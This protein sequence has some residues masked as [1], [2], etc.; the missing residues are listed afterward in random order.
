MT[1]QKIANYVSKIS[2][3]LLLGL[4]LVWF[5]AIIASSP[6]L[7]STSA[8]NIN[9]EAAE[10]PDLTIELMPDFELSSSQLST[11][12]ETGS[13]ILTIPWIAQ[14]IQGLYKYG[15]A[16]AGVVAA[17]M[18]MVGGFLYLTAADSGRVSRG[19]QIIVDAMLGLLL[20]IFA[21][22]ILTVINP[23]LTTLSP[24]KVEYIERQTW[25]T[26]AT[27]TI[28][29]GNPDAPVPADQASRTSSPVPGAS[30]PPPAATSCSPPCGPSR[31]ASGPVPGSFSASITSCPYTPQVTDSQAGKKAISDKAYRE[32]FYS[33]M[34]DR[35]LI[36]ASTI[37]ER[38]VLIAQAAAACKVKIG[39]CG[40]T[41]G[42]ISALAGVGRANPPTCMYSNPNSCN[43]TRGQA[44]N[45]LTSEQR[46]QVY[47]RRCDWTPAA[48]KPAGTSA[49]ATKAREKNVRM[50]AQYDRSDCV[51][52]GAAAKAGFIAFMQAEAAAGRV[53]DNWPDGWADKLRPGDYF[54]C[55][56]G[57]ADLTGSH[58]LVFLGWQGNRAQVVD[59]S[60]GGAPS[61]HTGPCL[62]SSCGASLCPL[63]GVYSAPN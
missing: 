36:R 7:A 58:A 53:R 3:L 4:L 31:P 15:V 55:Y 63:T 30:A 29:T 39:S 19:K 10:A 41:A 8:A 60:Y 50:H 22:G 11:D 57:N 49:S 47:A 5:A 59:A 34:L 48:D 25:D 33:K 62:K 9:V 18:M 27:T 43:G 2:A 23:G 54:V 42:T 24:L 1:A 44:L 35:S 14:Y 21:Y 61:F 51:S 28:D 56:N 16:I 40:T 17:V 46:K 6:V 45:E 13:K 37:R 38:V 20:V 12:V 32:E 52:S 26:L